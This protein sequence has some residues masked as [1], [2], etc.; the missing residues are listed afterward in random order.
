MTISPN[1]AITPR[2]FAAT[3]RALPNR[4]DCELLDFELEGVPV[5]A[6]ISRF[7]DGSIAE[8]FLDAGK[9]GSAV[10]TATRDG[11]IAVSLAL[12]H[13]CD[14]A[15]IRHAL[16]RLKDGQAAGHIGRALDLLAA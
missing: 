9:P 10:G 1:D 6:C 7:A 3:R 2:Q 11:A 14:V 4:R 15:T 12:Q 5:T 8:L 13:G 16:T